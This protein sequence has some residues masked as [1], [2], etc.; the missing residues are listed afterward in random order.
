MAILAMGSAQL[1]FGVGEERESYLFVP[2]KVLA[3]VLNWDSG[4]IKG[5]DGALNRNSPS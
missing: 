1:R 2:I 5:L 3:V 4:V